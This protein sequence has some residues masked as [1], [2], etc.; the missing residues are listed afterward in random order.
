MKMIVKKLNKE[1]LLNTINYGLRWFVYN[2]RK[3]FF[4]VLCHLLRDTVKDY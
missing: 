4:M 1:Y 3:V 2:E